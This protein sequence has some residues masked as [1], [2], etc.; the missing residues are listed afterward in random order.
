M[1][2]TSGAGHSSN[3]VNFGKLVS[4]VTGYGEAYNP[5]QA[6]LSINSMQILNAKSEHAFKALETADSAFKS[7]RSKRKN[8]FTPFQKVLTRSW[9]AFTACAP[10]SEIMQTVK[11]MVHKI[12]GIRVSGRLTTEEK[13]ALK[14]Q[15][16]EINQISTTQM[17]FDNLVEN[18]GHYISLL[19]T[20][21]EYKPNE[22][23]LQLQQLTALCNQLSLA[24]LDVS[25]KYQPF[26]SARIARNEVLYT[27]TTGLVDVALLAK[28]YVRSVY[29]P[30]SEQYKQISGLKFRRA[31]KPENL[32]SAEPI[33]P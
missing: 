1:T 10:N 18:F 19:A 27:K 31:V 4:F 17:G 25:A 30:R 32:K 28:A 12:R 29:G 9:N 33:L 13:Q 14:D 6:V 21:P 22:S 15:G 20:V 24:N 5:S 16:K 7:A 3:V 11:S 2:N 8:L 23:G 26:S